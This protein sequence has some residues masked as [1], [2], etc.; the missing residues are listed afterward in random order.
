VF[1][2]VVIPTHNPNPDRFRRTIR[3]VRDQDFPS[4][5]R[6]LIVVDN[7]SERPLDPKILSSLAGLTIT[8][9]VEDRLGLTPAR[10]RGI[11]QANGEVIVFVDDDNVLA[12]DYLSVAARRFEADPKLGACGGKALPEFEITPPDWTKEF[13]QM[14][15]IRDLGPA[16]LRASGASSY[17]SCAPIGAGMAVRRQLALK[18][19]A[20]IEYDRVRMRL[21]RTGKSLAS[22]G[23][24]D[25]VLTVLKQ[26]FDV[27]YVPELV[28]THL[29]S[30]GRTTTGYL[31]Q[32]N[33]ASSRTW[34]RLLRAHNIRTG[35]TQISGIGAAVRKAR[36]FFTVRPW[37]AAPEYV[38]WR[39]ACG[40]FDGR[41]ST[42]VR[43]RA[44]R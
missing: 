25:L 20:E 31:A 39:G 10:I 1:V 5:Q 27:E 17:P 43:K 38:R 40:I 22:G 21:D 29:I 32:L 26:E 30:A 37:R 18:W 35:W 44:Q 15:A 36:S 6:E 9:V 24:N 11:R 23:D 8:V 13:W 16:S 2:S 28:L 4:H 41:I 34:V 14:L 3:A 7:G 12:T 33:Y 42:N 19:A